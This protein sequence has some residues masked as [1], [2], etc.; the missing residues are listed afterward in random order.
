MGLMLGYKFIEL[1]LFYSYIGKRFSDFENKKSLNPY[2]ILDGNLS[3]KTKIWEINSVIK[4]EVNNLTNT[5]YET[6][7]GYPMPLR[8]FMLTLTIN[9]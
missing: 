1:N 2:N 4:I 5:S 3:I 8:N 6:I 7:S 9:Y